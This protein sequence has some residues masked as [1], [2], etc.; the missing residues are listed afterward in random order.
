MSAQTNS[1]LTTT[2]SLQ[3]PTW[4]N[5]VLVRLGLKPSAVM[6]PVATSAPA[7]AV[8]VRQYGQTN[9]IAILSLKGPLNVDTCQDVLQVAKT[10]Y[11][12]GT[13]RLLI[14]LEDVTEIK[15]SGFFTLGNIIRL[16]ADQ[17][18][19]N[20]AGGWHAIEQMAQGWQLTQSTPVKLLTSPAN[21]Y[22]IL[23]Q[24]RFP[25]RLPIYTEMSEALRAFE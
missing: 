23:A 7:I 5:N 11:Q 6:P 14:N 10:V 2:T 3:L 20:P 9:P 17:P 12:Q 18:L 1:V 13:R 4:V 24:T 15:L 22:L 21:L 19:I 25:Q 16:F 8:T